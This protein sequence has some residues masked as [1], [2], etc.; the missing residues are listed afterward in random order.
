MLPNRTRGAPQ[1]WGRHLCNGLTLESDALPV[2]LHGELLQEV[3]EVLEP[4]RIRQ[5]HVSVGA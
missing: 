4:L 2:T 3:G 1:H 5:Y